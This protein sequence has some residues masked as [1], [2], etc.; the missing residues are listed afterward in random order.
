M[1]VVQGQAQDETI[2][3]SAFEAIFWALVLPSKDY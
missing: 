1:A 3:A 2:A